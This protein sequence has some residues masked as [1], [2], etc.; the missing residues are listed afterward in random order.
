MGV[1]PGV[2]L[3]WI[4]ALFIAGNSMAFSLA[5]NVAEATLSERRGLHA[6]LSLGT[7]LVVGLTAAPLLQQLRRAWQKRRIG[8][9]GLFASGICG[10]TAYSIYAMSL[11]TAPVYFEVVSVLLV[12][13]AFGAH[14]KTWMQMRIRSALQ[15]AMPKRDKCVRVSPDRRVSTVM[16]IADVRCGDLLQ[17]DAGQ[18]VPIDGT[19]CAG[20]SYVN[21]AALTGEG[22]CVARRCGDHVLAGSETIDGQIIVRADKN[23]TQRQLDE[24]FSRVVHGLSQKSQFELMVDRLA[25]YFFPVVASVCLLTFV[26]WWACVGLA[27]AFLHA[28]AV[29]LVACPCA[30]GFATPIGMW[31]AATRLARL[32]VF[33]RD[34]AAIERL[35]QVTTVV[36]DK[37]GT[38]TQA[39][40]VATQVMYR[41]NSPHPPQDILAM[42][43]AAERMCCHPIA[44]ALVQLVAGHAERG[45]RAQSVEI[46][47]SRGV[48][49]QVQGPQSTHVVQ[50]GELADLATEATQLLA[51][52]LV[53]N[54]PA[55]SR[56]IAIVVDA[57]LEAIVGL[58]EQPLPDARDT[59]KTLQSSGFACH[60]FSGDKA[61]RLQ[62]WQSL[63]A[64]TASMSPTAKAAKV[65]QMQAVGQRVCFVG[66]GLNDAPALA[67]SMSS[68]AFDSGADLAVHTA[69]FILLTHRLAAVH[70]A[71][72][73]A[74][75]TMRVVRGNVRLALIYNLIGMAVAALGFLHPVF[76][77]VSMLTSSLV[78]TLRSAQL[79][80]MRVGTG[81]ETRASRFGLVGRA[82][83]II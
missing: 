82:K 67:C 10:A 31:T 40:L 18:A 74:R 24:I 64:V 63:S 78:V 56:Q 77:A 41:S 55:G 61:S 8:I 15:T 28:M 5:V 47:P 30:L 21:E 79:L 33:S 22:F 4:I 51:A 6:L 50:L 17:V 52:P 72:Q 69:D 46:L 39:Q 49:V 14:V 35:A 60:I 9:E 25:R 36:F 83:P 37:T 3:R 7:A 71:I 20:E 2:W 1:L 62:D 80:S 53:Q 42:A 19:I 59:L 26:G 57:Q 43:A 48:R 58:A 76:A 54:L 65:E 66:D 75:Q 70:E 81:I 13:Y 12:T 16:A 68:M 34:T 44:R 32:G 27:P 11:P 29:L 45:Y 38:L 73:I 23:G